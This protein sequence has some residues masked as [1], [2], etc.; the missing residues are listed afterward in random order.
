MPS[1]DLYIKRGEIQKVNEQ[2]VYIV[3][4]LIIQDNVEFETE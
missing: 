2:R 3:I 1:F 4:L